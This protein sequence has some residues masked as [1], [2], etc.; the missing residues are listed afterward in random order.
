MFYVVHAIS[1]NEIEPPALNLSFVTLLA[2]L[3]GVLSALLL[4]VAVCKDH[5]A[6]KI[7]E[8]H[9]PL[10]VLCTLIQIIIAARIN[11]HFGSDER[12][13]QCSS[14]TMHSLYGTSQTK[15]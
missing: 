2:C 11:V 13:L 10:P 15:Q 6:F 7:S 9:Q 5:L 3:K 12:A 1:V 4:V 14:Q 8:L